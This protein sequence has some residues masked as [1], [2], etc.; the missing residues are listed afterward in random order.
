MHRSAAP[1]PLAPLISG[2]LASP[3]SD[4]LDLSVRKKRVLK[5]QSEGDQVQSHDPRLTR[6][7]KM[8]ILGK[9]KKHSIFFS[10]VCF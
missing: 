8:H 4:P 7:K 3:S 9:K 1:N 5:G 6:G 2:H 10:A